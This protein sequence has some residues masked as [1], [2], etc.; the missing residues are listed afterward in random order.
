MPD[1][2][3]PDLKAIFNESFGPVMG[4]VDGLK[5]DLRGIIASCP[6]PVERKSFEDMLEVVSFLQAETRREIPPMVDESIA[7]INASM[8][9]IKGSHAR[10]EELGARIQEL[11]RQAREMPAPPRERPG[12]RELGKAREKLAA[13]RVGTPPAAAPVPLADGL[14]LRRRLFGLVQPAAEPGARAA[15]LHNIWENWRPDDAHQPD[16]D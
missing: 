8:E 12:A 1:F 6:D 2:D 16:S 3:L 4:F 13:I 7:G 9:S 14:E 15:R 11:D 10:I 5:S